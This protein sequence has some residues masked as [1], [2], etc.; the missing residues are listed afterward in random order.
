MGQ[1]VTVLGTH[2]NINAYGDEGRTTSTLLEGMVRL[3]SGAQTE[4]LSPGQQAVT[5]PENNSGIHVSD[6]AN[7]AE[8]IAWKND[9]FQFEE[10]DIK[11]IMNQI[12]RWYD[13]DIVYGSRVPTDHYKGKVSRNVNASQA[14]KILA[15]SGINFKIE[16]KKIIV[17]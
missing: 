3:S 17:N 14:L 2:F 15:A 16:G 11:T 5:V 7:I 6:N 1:T 9:L 13:V 4:V 12:G 10:A 8:V